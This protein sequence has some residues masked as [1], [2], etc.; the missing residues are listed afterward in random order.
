[1]NEIEISIIIPCFNGYRYSKKCIQSLENQTYKN[2]E[3]IV[4]DDCSTDNSYIEFLSLAEKSFLKIKVLKNK[5][6]KGPGYSRKLGVLSAVGKYICFCD[7]DDWLENNFF[8][9]MLLKVQKTSCDCVFCDYNYVTSYDKVTATHW[10]KEINDLNNKGELI[11]Y[12]QGSLC[13]LM[14]KKEILEGIDFPALYHGEDA[15]LIPIIVCKSNRVSICEEPLYNYLIRE[16]SASN[17]FDRRPFDASSKVFMYIQKNIDPIYL[18]ECEFLGIKGVLY[19]GCL[20]GIK[21]KVSR[22]EIK[23]LVKDFMKKYPEFMRN[24][25]FKRMN[26]AKKAFVFFIWHNLYICADLYAFLHTKY[27]KR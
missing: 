24:P 15:A 4:V 3:V 25:Y 22:S 21:A 23:W 14:V 26:K 5:V 13:I 1:M 7:C 11:A 2:F 20:S 17:I 19:S 10:Y 9:K 27:L 8:E 16:G 6:N 18:K 12:A